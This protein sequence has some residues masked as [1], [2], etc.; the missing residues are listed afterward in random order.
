M[1]EALAERYPDD[2]ETYTAMKSGFINEILE[3]AR[4][5]RGE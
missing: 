4:V 1:K 2:R 5:W 3:K